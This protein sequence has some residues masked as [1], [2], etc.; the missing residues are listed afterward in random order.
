[1]YAI[2]L[3]IW[4]L[5]LLNKYSMAPQYT[6]LTPIKMLVVFTIITI[7][8]AELRAMTSTAVLDI[9]DLSISFPSSGSENKVVHGISFSVNAGQTLA[10]VGES[11]SGKSISA[12]SIMKLLPNSIASI[13]ADS[14][15]YKNQD[16]KDLSEK[17]LL[18][19]RGGKVA[20]IFQ[21]PMSSLN[22]SHTCGRQVDE[23]LR[24]HTSLDKESRRARVLQLFNQVGIDDP[25]R[26]YT[27]YPH[28]LSGGQLQRVVI[29]MAISCKPSVLIADEPTTALD[30]HVQRQIIELLRD[31]Q[32]ESGMAL[33]FISH[34]LGVVRQI[35]DEVIVMRLGKVVEHGSVE[36]VFNRPQHPYTAGLIASRP[37]MDYRLS[38]LPTV[39][40]YE[41]SHSFFDKDKYLIQPEVFAERQEKIRQSE[42]ILEV[43][44]IKKTYTSSSGFWSSKKVHKTVLD[45]I[46][47]KVR[48]GETL[49]LVGESGCGKSTLAN[50]I[51]GLIPPSSGKILYKGQDIHELLSTSKKAY[52]K[53][54]QIVFQDP[55]SS[56][57]P[58][59]TIGNAIMEPMRIHGLGSASERKER[60]AGLLRDVGL[61]PDH[62]DR[63]PHQFSGGQRQRINIARA[64]AVEPSLLVCD[65]SVSALDVSVQ[66][67]V[68]NMLQ[69]LKAQYDLTYVF[70][71]HDIS[72]IHHVSDSVA[73]MHQGRIAEYGDVQSV[74]HY[75]QSPYTQSLLSAVMI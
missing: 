35:A 30:V 69:D 16:V 4:I 44:D 39:K 46:R 73:V 63:Y 8:T 49:G 50:I 9:R 22:P 54:V 7:F 2:L 21:E 47:L 40:D 61:L 23:M 28:Q 3:T 65:E 52:R 31:L 45:S 19:Y 29:A 1:M 48:K 60:A 11:G 66:A 14:I 67:Q 72:V 62:M 43:R 41:N 74:I 37:P 6:K 58:R 38:I 25:D 70:I 56:L 68:L 32:K 20:Y 26:A 53:E 24:L 12:L 36:D 10:I 17:E 75:P 18:A 33:V 15:T 13:R 5:S 27:S 34:D 55:Y 59:V 57:N 51:L 71:S 64:L 42:V